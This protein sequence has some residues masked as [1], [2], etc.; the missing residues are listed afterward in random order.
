MKIEKICINFEQLNALNISIDEFIIL[1]NFYINGKKPQPDQ[2]DQLVN[3]EHIKDIGMGRYSIQPNIRRLLHDSIIKK[4]KNGK[5]VHEKKDD[6]LKIKEIIRNRIDEYRQKWKGIKAGAMGSPRACSEK[7]FA[8]MKDNPD[9]TFDHILKAADLYISQCDNPRY[10]QRADYF[11]Y[12]QE[13]NGLIN[14]TLSAFI[15]SIDDH[16]EDGWTTELL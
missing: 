1:L 9:Y 12:K 16:E 13:K 4:T 7:L 5:V 15:D 11:I 8:W 3:N 6:D 14:S 10:V 2:I